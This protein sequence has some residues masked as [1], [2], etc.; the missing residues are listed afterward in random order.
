M[1]IGAAVIWI[2]KY[3]SGLRVK[4]RM[5]LLSRFTEED[6]L[7]SIDSIGLESSHYAG[8]LGYATTSFVEKLDFDTDRFTYFLER[9]VQS[10]VYSVENA[11]YRFEGS[12]VLVINRENLEAIPLNEIADDLKETE[13]NPNVTSLGYRKLLDE[14]SSE[15]L[16][17]YYQDF[18]LT[19][20]GNE[21]LTIEGYLKE[22]EFRQRL[23][24]Y[25]DSTDREL[26]MSLGYKGDYED[27]NTR[28]IMVEV[29]QRFKKDAKEH[30]LKKL[31]QRC[32]EDKLTELVKQLAL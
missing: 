4:E 2:P 20:A 29:K 25:F 9:L 11:L 13:E 10:S 8:A 14:F 7:V 21:E 22:I 23:E 32:I 12:N 17:Q 30:T 16:G 18:L 1:K 26:L 27:I 6:E 15:F 3:E 24:E 19:M 5:E 31:K 28:G